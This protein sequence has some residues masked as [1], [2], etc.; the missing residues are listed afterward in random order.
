M[1]ISPPITRASAAI[2]LAVLAVLVA[3]VQNL[4]TAAAAV[5]IRPP[6]TSFTVAMP[7]DAGRRL[8]HGRI[9]QNVA[10]EAFSVI[11]ENAQMLKDLKIVANKHNAARSAVEQPADLA[12]VFKIIK[13]LLPNYTARDVPA[14]R[15]PVKAKVSEAFKSDPK[16][17]SLSLKSTKK[18]ALIDFLAVIGKII[19]RACDSDNIQA[20]FIAAGF[21]DGQ[22]LRYPVLNKIL[23]TCRRNI[24]KEECENVLD[25]FEQFLITFDEQGHI[26]EEMF[27][28]YGFVNDFGVDGQIYRRDAG[29]TQEQLQRAKCLTHDFQINLRKQRLLDCQRTERLK[30]KRENAKHQAK[31]DDNKAAV[32]RLN[33]MLKADDADDMFAELSDFDESAL[34]HCKLE[35][36]FNLKA[37]ELVSFI[38]ARNPQ[39]NTKSSVPAKGT[40]QEAKDGARKSVLI[41][42]ESRSMPNRLMNSFPHDLSEEEHD[43]DELIEREQSALNVEVIDLSDKEW[44]LP[45]QLLSNDQWVEQVKSGFNINYEVVT[46]FDRAANMETEEATSFIG[47][48]KAKADLLLK[49]LRER[50]KA[51]VQ[52]RISKKSKRNHW[53]M[54]LAYKNLNVVAAVMVMADH[55]KEDI[56]CI[57]EADCI[58]ASSSNNF[59]PCLSHPKRQGVYGYYDVNRGCFVRSGKVTRRGFDD[60]GSE[61]EKGAKAVTAS[62]HFYDVYPS[63]SSSRAGYRE[64]QGYFESLRQVILM[65]F[66][67]NSE[68]ARSFD[69]DIA[70]GGIL[71]LDNDDKASILASMNTAEG[72]A[73][74]TPIQ[75]FHDII[76]YQFE[77]GYDLAIAPDTEPRVRV[78][79]GHL[80]W[81]RVMLFRKTLSFSTS[82]ASP[83]FASCVISSHVYRTARDTSTA[84]RGT[85]LASMA[86]INLYQDQLARNQA[87]AVAPEGERD[88]LDARG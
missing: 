9:S 23:A 70:D 46:I 66:D 51:H 17:K 49:I 37:P 60:R 38:T 30:K 19:T 11:K 72:R 25:T 81:Q 24:T 65:G 63:K 4:P 59:I 12:K 35:H 77:F 83:G 61:H 87:G 15:V 69:R 5:T 78:S 34:E 22:A 75:K 84:M 29:I 28:L 80:R 1:S 67:P 56:T 58:L 40:L 6:T 31:V 88:T 52:N 71:L 42:F 36:F 2:I 16:L 27:D 7:T 20:G 79:V 62:S 54:K 86:S 57:Q 41:A 39:H 68:G 48:A 74:L 50:Y 13:E 44:A 10:D 76:S 82:L 21:I 14:D 26:P 8:W 85:P 64:K 18:G 33:G 55:V 32:R 3:L 53:V 47:S 43:D 73:N 45:S